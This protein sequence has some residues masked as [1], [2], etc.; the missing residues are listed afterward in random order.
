ML[1]N[2]PKC[3]YS[4]PQDTYCASCGVDIVKFSARH[5]PAK[6]PFWKNPSAL[7]GIAAVMGIFSI[8]FFRHKMQMNAGKNLE[9]NRGPARVSG[10][11]KKNVA[12]LPPPPPTA[13][14][15]VAPPPP[16]PSKNERDMKAGM[17]YASGEV[18]GAGAPDK[19]HDQ[20]FAAVS[21]QDRLDD[22]NRDGS[23]SEN[24]DL[25]G[26]PTFP[27]R[28]T[29]VEIPTNVLDQLVI[30]QNKSQGRGLTKEAVGRLWSL[31]R[32]EP[33]LELES[34]V[35]GFGAQRSSIKKSLLGGQESDER[36]DAQGQSDAKLVLDAQ[37]QTRQP[38]GANRSDLV[39]GTFRLSNHFKLEEA[40]ISH[41]KEKDYSASFSFQKGGAWIYAIDLPTGDVD[42]QLSQ[43]SIFKVYRSPSFQKGRSKVTLVVEIE[44]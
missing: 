12:V 21:R 28:F 40:G 24:A 43:S 19:G 25:D 18:V 34:S 2:C 26:Q 5:K 13:D 7:I 10:S 44:K 14:G 30:E 23:H 8:W 17:V 4:Q 3:G 22:F 27:V 29:F 16:P 41:S 11:T 35:F 42:Q 9:T 37:I 32:K 15:Q 31:V 36:Y 20:K 33:G 38:A 1:I 6:L 39:T